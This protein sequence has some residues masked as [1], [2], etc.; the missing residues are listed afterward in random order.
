MTKSKTSMSL[1]PV[2]IAFGMVYRKG[3]KTG[4]DRALLATAGLLAAL[5]L[6]TLSA[7]NTELITRIMQDPDALTG[8]T[9]IWQADIAYLKDHFALG[10]GFEAVF[11][12]GGQ[13]PLANYLHGRSWVADVSNSHNGYLEIFLGLG[14]IGFVL[15]LVVLVAI[16]FAKFWPLNRDPARDGYFA[17]F[18]FIVFHNFTEADFLAPDGV[19]WMA[20]LM[21]LSAIKSPAAYPVIRPAPLPGFLKPAQRLPF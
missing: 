15:A 19:L 14:A 18:I 9:E 16:P 1:L 8:R 5:A 20:F 4:L 13:S 10:A 17:I 21:V 7:L 12:T 3:W 6:G 11:G 2:A